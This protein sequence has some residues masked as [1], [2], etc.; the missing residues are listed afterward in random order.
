MMRKS[1]L[2][3]TAALGT[4]ALAFTGTLLVGGSS[5]ST[6]A[7]AS[8]ATYPFS[9]PVPPSVVIGGLAPASNGPSARLTVTTPGPDSDMAVLDYSG[10]AAFL[11]SWLG[12][13]VNAQTYTTGPVSVMY[14]AT[15]PA[16][17]FASP[18][19][20]TTTSGGTVGNFGLFS[21]L[22]TPSP[23]GFA[24]SVVEA[25]VPITDTSGTW[26]TAADVL[27]P[28][29]QGDVA[30]VTGFTDLGQTV[31]AAAPA[32]SVTTASVTDPPT[33]M[34]EPATWVLLG[35]CVIGLGIYRLVPRG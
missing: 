21:M 18:T 26:A 13:N 11:L 14:A 30:A 5:C 33:S 29:A 27:T 23:G 3:S 34:P 10:V 9:P 2:A 16:T 28:N 32:S 25:Q 20:T 35:A 7:Q 17:P 31:S 1:L 12:A 4:A 15:G 22:A 19:Y 8:V 6:C 24:Q